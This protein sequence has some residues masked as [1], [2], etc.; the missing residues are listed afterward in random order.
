L[1]KLFLRE[2]KEGNRKGNEI[3]RDILEMVP[4]MPSKIT[5]S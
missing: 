1:K 2:A 3:G 4:L 5:K